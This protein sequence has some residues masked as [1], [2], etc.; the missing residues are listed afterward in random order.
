MTKDQ[1][2]IEPPLPKEMN[3]PRRRI[4]GFG[5]QTFNIRFTVKHPLG[6]TSL[7]NGFGIFHHGVVIVFSQ[8]GGHRDL[9][10]ASY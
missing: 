10:Q 4:S 1:W 7:C 8:T 2:Y 6:Q 3:S 5:V 9:V